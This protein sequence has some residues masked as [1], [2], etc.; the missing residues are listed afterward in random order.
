MEEQL[1]TSV[2]KRVEREFRKKSIT[3][4]SLDSGF[5]MAGKWIVH[6][7]G[8]SS[9]FVK[10]AL[11]QT[12][13]IDLRIEYLIY[14][15]I[16][17]DFLP[18]LLGWSD[19]T[20]NPVLMLEDLSEAE[21]SPL[22]TNKRIDAVLKTLNDIIATPPPQELQKVINSNNNKGF[23]IKIAEDPKSFLSLG[24]CNHVWLETALPIL[25]SAEA[26][27]P[28]DG[29]NLIHLDV[30][31]EN[32]C[33]KNEKAILL[34]WSYAFV[35]NGKLTTAKWL[36]SLYAD[37]GPPPCKILPNEPE[38]ASFVSGYWAYY[39]GLFA[40]AI[41]LEKLQQF[42]LMQL[43]SSL[44]WSVRELYLPHPEGILVQ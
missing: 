29:E 25:I 6:F 43:K 42:Q 36:P 4:S 13:A 22:W 32:L 9:A 2:T 33:F 27:A 26:S 21:W 7:E 20:E 5:S 35:G 14:S 15:R 8:G 23:W 41:G 34:D 24:I 16:S 18:A 1:I 28:I 17:S 12:A 3:W 31:S 40:N 37:G 39:A 10:V 30:R 19:D 44:L 38:L 11:D